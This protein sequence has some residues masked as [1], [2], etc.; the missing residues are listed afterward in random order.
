MTEPAV[1]PP[2]PGEVWVVDFL[3]GAIEN[4]RAFAD[5][6]ELTGLECPAGDLRM[7]SDWQEFRRCFDWL[8]RWALERASLALAAES[9]LAA[10]REEGASEATERAAK[11]AED[12]WFSG[13]RSIVGQGIA[14]DIAAAIRARTLATPGTE[15]SDE[16]SLTIGEALELAHNRA[17]ATTGDSHDG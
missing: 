17:R 4:G 10:A 9:A 16:P 14:D 7:C 13:H 3:M 11:I 12:G 6:L 5:R 2:S 15:R 8:A 1:S